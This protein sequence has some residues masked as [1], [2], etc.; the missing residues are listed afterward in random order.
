[1]AESDAEV[2]ARSSDVPCDLEAEKAVIACCLLDN[3]VVRLCLDRLTMKSFVHPGHQRLWQAILNMEWD[4]TAIDAI[5]VADWLITRES[6]AS[7]GGDDLLRDVLDSVEHAGNALIYADLVAE[8]RQERIEIA[9]RQFE[10]KA[11]IASQSAAVKASSSYEQ[12]LTSDEWKFK[13]RA[14]K[15]F[16]GNRCQACNVHGDSAILDTHH[17]TYERLG[18]EVP[19]DLIVL[20]RECHRIFHENGKLAKS[21]GKGR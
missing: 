20:C 12:H 1:M 6:F 11:A 14:M 21:P 4:G 18:D 2:N 7:I 17:R 10:A 9:K 19:S 16:A 13:A 3:D 8:K 5:T 15:W